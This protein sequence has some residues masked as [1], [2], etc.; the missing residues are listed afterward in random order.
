MTEPCTIKRR[1]QDGSPFDV[2]CP[3]LLPDYQQFMRGVD[4]GNQLI[5]FYIM[6]GG[7]QESGGRDVFHTCITSTINI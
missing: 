7:G 1:N 4:R 6:L 5:G 2:S 3:L